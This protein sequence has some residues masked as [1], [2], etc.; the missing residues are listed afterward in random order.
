MLE[1]YGYWRCGRCGVRLTDLE[2][3]EAHIRRRMEV[4][5]PDRAGEAA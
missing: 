4:K 2:E 3:V 5:N 1:Y